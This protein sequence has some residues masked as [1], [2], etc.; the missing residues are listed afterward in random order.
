MDPE[1]AQG[2]RREVVLD[3]ERATNCVIQFV[4]S[5]TKTCAHLRAFHLSTTSE[6]LDSLVVPSARAACQSLNQSKCRPSFK[7]KHPNASL[8]TCSL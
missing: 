4:D 2:E 7:S 8:S 5:W 6:A 3:V 1:K